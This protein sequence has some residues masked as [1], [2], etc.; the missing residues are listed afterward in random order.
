VGLAPVT[1]PSSEICLYYG[2]E[3][4]LFQ[5]FELLFQCVFG[6]DFVSVSIYVE[7]FLYILQSYSRT[8]GSQEQEIKFREGNHF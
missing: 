5:G 4:L 3:L 7:Q 8:V 2:Y 6:C 1:P